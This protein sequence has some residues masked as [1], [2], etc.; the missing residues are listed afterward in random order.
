M[1]NTRVGFFV[2]SC[3]LV[4]PGERVCGGGGFSDGND[5]VVVPLFTSAETNCERALEGSCGGWFCCDTVV[6]GN[7][8]QGK[9]LLLEYDKCGTL[10]TDDASPAAYSC[11]DGVKGVVVVPV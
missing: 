5:V 10:E 1:K 3:G 8:L 7:E 6:D 2:G 4:E 11:G 9:L